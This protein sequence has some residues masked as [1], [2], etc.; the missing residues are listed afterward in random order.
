M[1][2]NV[3]VTEACKRYWAAVFDVLDAAGDYAQAVKLYANLIDDTTRWRV[4]PVFEEYYEGKIT[5]LRD[6]I[7]YRENQFFAKVN[8]L[9]ILCKEN[10]LMTVTKPKAL[11]DLLL[12]PNRRRSYRDKATRRLKRGKI[13]AMQDFEK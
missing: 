7:T 2:E 1:A 8:K 3:K 6:A 4:E 5:K 13:C 12:N 9:N 11:L 10:A